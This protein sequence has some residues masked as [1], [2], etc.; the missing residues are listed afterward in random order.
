MRKETAH[1]FA[2][3]LGMPANAIITATFTKNMAPATINTTSFTVVN[4]TTGGTPVAGTVPYAVASRTAT[5]TPTA[6][7]ATIGDTYTA[8]FTSAATDL[9]GNALAGNQ[10]PLPAASNYAWTFTTVA[11]D[12]S[13]PT[14]TLTAPANTAGGRLFSVPPLSLIR[15]SAY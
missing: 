11:T 8:T 6:L 12:L 9:A 1:H 10:A 15:P 7:L 14:V 5:F 4:T 2:G 3:R 13:P